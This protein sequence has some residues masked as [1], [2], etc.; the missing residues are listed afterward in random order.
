MTPRTLDQIRESQEGCATVRN[1]VTVLRVKLDLAASYGLYE[2]E[3]GHEGRDDCATVFRDLAA[4][5]RR[6]IGVLLDLLDAGSAAGRPH[7]FRR[8][9]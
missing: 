1:V 6:E 4:R 2:Y 8:R 3:A 7:R 9:E 5:E